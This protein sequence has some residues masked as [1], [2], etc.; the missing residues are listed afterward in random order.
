MLMSFRE[1]VAEIAD[2]RSSIIEVKKERAGKRSSFRSLD[3]LD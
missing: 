3:A 2:G 1:I